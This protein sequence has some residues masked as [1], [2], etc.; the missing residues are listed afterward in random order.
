[1]P[2]STTTI[3]SFWSRPWTPSKSGQWWSTS[4]SKETGAQSEA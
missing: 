2:P 4:F 1:L 3:R